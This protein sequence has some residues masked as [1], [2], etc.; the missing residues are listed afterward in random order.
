MHGPSAPTPGV[1]DGGARRLIGI[2]AGKVTTSLVWGRL[3][4]DGAPVV[5]PF[6]HAG[7]GTVIRNW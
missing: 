5:E 2:D 7:G 1:G 3:G 6:T 4:A